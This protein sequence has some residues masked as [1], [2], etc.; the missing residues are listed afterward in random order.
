LTISQLL[1]QT[2]MKQISILLIALSFSIA[3]VAQSW[4]LTGNAGT[5]PPTNFVGTTDNNRLVFK[6]NAVEGMTLLPGGN[7]GIGLTN[8]SFTLHVYSTTA[9]AHG[10][11]SGSNPGI[12]FFP[13][14]TLSPGADGRIGLVTT[15]N[16]FI[17]GTIS[18]DFIMEQS[19]TVNS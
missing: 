6:S 5:N 4:S 9:G 18:G 11:F 15:A 16:A 1:N 3:G 12:N 2:I 14:A 7:V 17:A 13:N 19:D 8:P 10:A